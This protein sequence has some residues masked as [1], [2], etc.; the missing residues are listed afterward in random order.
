MIC[1]VYFTEKI[2]FLHID[3]LTFPPYIKVM[4]AT[5]TSKG[6]ITIPVGIRKK[7]NLKPGDVLEF[8]ETA[9]FLK[10]SKTIPPEAWDKLR[11]GWTDPF[12]GMTVFE[13]L[14][15]M[16]GKVDLPDEAT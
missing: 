6:Q 13:I 7:L 14:D 15:E 1:Q 2:H 11:E 4:N 16:R 8:D 3:L 9:S 10:A 12:P 5:L